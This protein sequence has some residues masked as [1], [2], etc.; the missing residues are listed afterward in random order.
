MKV[1][2][3]H[4][5]RDLA[6]RPA[7]HDPVIDA[8]LAGDL[9]DRALIRRALEHTATGVT[10]RPLAALDAI[11]AQDLELGTL[12]SV[13]AN[14]DEYLFEVAKRV[15]L[16]PL[17]SPDE[18][19]YRQ[20]VLADCTAQPAVVRALY[21]LA[22][23]AL[24]N[25]RKIGGIWHDTSPDRLLHWAVEVL[26]LHVD[27]LRRLRTLADDH[28]EK[29]QSD[30]FARFF[31]MLKTEL[32]D[33]YL[34]LIEQH[35]QE[36][37][38][39]R[40][41]LLSAELDDGSKGRHYMVH[42]RRELR[43]T[44]RLSLAARPRGYSFTIPARDENGFRALDEIRGNGL[45]HTA[46]AVAQ[47]ADHVKSLFAMLR[48]EL[49]FYLACL[50]LSEQLNAKGQPVCF[51]DP[52]PA[53]QVS[54]VTEGLYDPGLT[55]HLDA[56]VVGNDVLAADKRLV[57]VTGA[58]QGGKSTFL[59]SVG[60]AQ[61]M[62]QSGMFVAA[63][64]FQANVC[65]GV[66]THYKREEDTTMRSGK[67]DEELAR[68]SAI[69][70][71]IT[72]DALLLCNESFAA[73]NERE[74][75]E[76]AR[77]IVHAMLD[78]HIKVLFVTHMYDFAH[79]FATNPSDTTLFLRAER[80]TDGTRTYR[81]TEEA[82]IPTSYGEDTYRRIFGSDTPAPPLATRRNVDPK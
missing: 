25:E 66:F 26:A 21:D 3:L 16:S 42:N 82:P 31:A 46:N 79:T 45:S 71:Q 18:I 62:M 55:L 12:W 14:G 37:Q 63:A 7:L 30:G 57:I 61:L 34:A 15:L 38:F 20:R 64:A 6:L 44:K 49:A 70:D 39:K 29:F 67:L 32:D 24:T 53:E 58:N 10:E 52:L 73:T 33:D 69:A 17:T 22:L 75:S 28:A 41:L 56:R 5:D 43:W 50:N 77:Q 76:I 60:V 54:M 8:I 81:L 1:Y 68:M 9:R 23:E 4:P 35:L 80:L 51:P 74:G 36:L 27:V 19:R 78:K 59:R 72:P 11:L 2:L 47:S 48:V 65:S 13:M 40:G